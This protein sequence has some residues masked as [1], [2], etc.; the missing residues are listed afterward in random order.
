VVAG[1]ATLYG[2]WRFSRMK[3][4]H[5]REN[6]TQ[7]EAPDKAPLRKVVTS[8]VIILAMLALWFGWQAYSV[9][10]E[11]VAIARAITGGDPANAETSLTRYGCAG[12]HTIPG[13]PGAHGKVG[14][15]LAELRKRVYVGGVLRNSPDNLI[16][17]IVA[18]Q[19]YS[20]NSAMPVTG[21]SPSEARDVA[22]YLYAY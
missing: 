5:E 18:P 19:R 1:L 2:W 12:C 3:P 7:S 20:P 16:A 14:P 10:S 6:P 4:A 15:P 11:N 22:A 21:I 13:V 8:V 17:W 9:A